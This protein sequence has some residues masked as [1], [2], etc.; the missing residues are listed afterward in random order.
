MENIKYL[1]RTDSQDERLIKDV[2]EVIAI[3]RNLKKN[4][5][6]FLVLDSFPLVQNIVFIQASYCVNKNAGFFGRLMGNIGTY[7]VEAQTQGKHG[8][9][10]QYRKMIKSLSAVEKIFTD[11]IV[12]Q[13]P[14]DL[15]AWKDITSE[16]QPIM[17]ENAEKLNNAPSLN[18]DDKSK[19]AIK[20]LKT[21]PS[22]FNALIEIDD[23]DALKTVYDTCDINAYENPYNKKTALHLYKVPEELVRW[24]IVNGA[25]IEAGDIYGNTPL[26]H[27][28][29]VS[30]DKIKLFLELG[31][32]INAANNDGETPLHYAAD[33]H[34]ADT[35]NQLII[36]GADIFAE[37]N[38]LHLTPLAYALA[39]C[40]NIDIAK[41][42]KVAE[43][44]LDAGADIT[45]QMKENVERIGREFEFH[46]DIFN[47]EYITESDAGL[48]RLYELFDVAP[49]AAL[50]LP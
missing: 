21:L 7:Q 14:P 12:S 22:Y 36:H 34:D 11:Y 29:C 8:L 49:A 2:D 32:N 38:E 27:Q 19:S 16:F 1:L 25:D 20:K 23:V 48:T 47:K 31:A 46:R 17:E 24:L 15:S 9:L 44:F 41:M 3:L 39:R 33:R 40:R 37:E 45:T 10:T 4:D 50:R 42:A 13:K 26:H 35:V 5:E 30:C 6:Y 18:G 28:A 43:I